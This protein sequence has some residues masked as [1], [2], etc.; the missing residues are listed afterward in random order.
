MIVDL[1]KQYQFIIKKRRLKERTTLNSYNAGSSNISCI[2][3]DLSFLDLRRPPGRSFSNKLNSTGTTR[4]FFD[5]DKGFI[6]N[7]LTLLLAL[8]NFC[9]VRQTVVVLLCFVFFLGE[10]RRRKNTYR[11]IL[12]QDKRPIPD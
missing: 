9:F 6:F 7:P 8:L 12:T 10:K 4:S 3:N 1:I 5:S 2:F 11:I